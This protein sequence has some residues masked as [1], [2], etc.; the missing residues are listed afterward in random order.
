[1]ALAALTRQAISRYNAD[2]EAHFRE[3]REWLERRAILEEAK[4]HTVS[5]SLWLLN[6]GLVPAEDIDVTIEVGNALL[7]LCEAESEDAEAFE[8]GPPPAP[9][10]EPSPIDLRKLGLHSLHSLYGAPVFRP[11][12]LPSLME[13]RTSV[14]A[15][16]EGHGYAVEFECRRLK[17]YENI[18]IGV[19]L[20]LLRPGRIKPF[21]L[22]YR[23]TAANVTQLLQGDIPVIVRPKPSQAS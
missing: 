16:K 2:L 23:I 19:F 18:K 5:F 12:D 6:S 9:P 13:P 1:M 3:Y 4:A 8:L 20:A 14:S 10:E 11:P 21:E 7:T 17:H 22:H 15:K